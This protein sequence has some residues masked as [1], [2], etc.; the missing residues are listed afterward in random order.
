MSEPTSP[1]HFEALHTCPD[2]GARAGRFHTP[3][4]IVETPAFMPVGTRGTVKGIP[5]WELR[6]LGSQ[7]LLANTYHLHL[8][9]GED[10]VAELGGL[11]GFMG[12]DGPILTDSGGYQIFSL[13]EIRRIDEDGVSFKSVVDG[14]RIRLTPERAVE[15]QTK[16]GADVIMAFDHC[17]SN[18]LDRDEVETATRRTHDWLARCV[19]RHRELGGEERGQALFGIVQGG[20]FE[21]LRLR[22]VE[23]ITSHDLAGYAVGGVSVGEGRESMRR[24]VEVAAPALPAE[25]PRYLMG[26]GT[27]EDFLHAVGHG[28][29]LF[30]CVTPTR[31]GRTHQAF[32]SYGRVNL[33]NAKWERDAE[34]LDPTCACRTCTHFSRG[35]LRHL[36]KTGE[37]LAGILLS[38]HNLH[39][40]NEL[41][42]E[43]R[44]QLAAGTFGAWS[45]NYGVRHFSS[46]SPL[47]EVLPRVAKEKKSD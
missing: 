6:E 10:V 9:P 42:A 4:G 18:P 17:P 33:R 23:A 36:C 14:D 15:V 45:V 27:P 37:M 22:S 39:Y 1:F 38:L 20:A 43:M 16:L 24:A 40:F 26:I 47:L 44:R 32:T 41:L 46:P 30:D 2:T 31:H 21:D 7:M 13:S 5:P 8:R 19:R 3:H 25:K 28:C 12:W 35:Y 34:P 11:H 29:D